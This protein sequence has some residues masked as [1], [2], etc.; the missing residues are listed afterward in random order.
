VGNILIN[1]HACTFYAGKYWIVAEDYNG[2][3]VKNKSGSIAVFDSYIGGDLRIRR[4]QYDTLIGSNGKLFFIPLAET[5]VVIYSIQT[6]EYKSIPIDIQHRGD[7]AFA[8]AVLSGRY[9]YSFGINKWVVMRINV[10][11][12]EVDFLDGFASEL[13]NNPNICRED[14]CMGAQ[15]IIYN[16]KIIIPLRAVKGILMIDE[17]S[18]LW[19]I[20]YIESKGGFYSIT[21][22]N[23]QF[24]CGPDFVGNPVVVLNERYD[25]CREIIVSD[26]KVYSDNPVGLKTINSRVVLLS[27]DKI[28]G[29]KIEEF[30]I[31]DETN[32]DYTCNSDCLIVCS[33]RDQ[34]IE[35]INTSSMEKS[36][37]K[38]EVKSDC[39]VLN[40]LSEAGF[41]WKD[42]LNMLINMICE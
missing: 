32:F 7:L 26:E 20:H 30:M 1:A 9:I 23:G 38:C 42:D 17:N 18:S 5:S 3:F 28:D 41:L 10:E 29:S 22:L 12:D 6:K 19:N 13:E 35:E 39:P 33:R 8:G 15:A 2:L 16:E 36:I 24:F 27:K 25:K 4:G 11:T 37:L 40:D 14:F 34:S 21:E 31:L